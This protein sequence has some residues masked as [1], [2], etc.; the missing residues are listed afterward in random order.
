MDFPIQSDPIKYSVI[1]F[2]WPYR[3]VHDQVI[4]GLVYY[5]PWSQHLYN[6]LLGQGPRKKSRP[7]AQLCLD[8]KMMKNV[9]EGD[10]SSFGRSPSSDSTSTKK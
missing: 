1:V 6:V 7:P 9:V 5:I 4:K 3:Q 8:Q 2:P 10:S